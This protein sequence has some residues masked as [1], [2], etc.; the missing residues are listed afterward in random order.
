[1]CAS[2]LSMCAL[3]ENGCFVWLVMVGFFGIVVGV[4]LV[5]LIDEIVFSQQ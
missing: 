2:L 4:L 3:S 5:S 1:M